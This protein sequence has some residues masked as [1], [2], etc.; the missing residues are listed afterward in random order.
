MQLTLFPEKVAGTGL[1]FPVSAVK[2]LLHGFLAAELLRQSHFGSR[3]TKHPGKAPVAFVGIYDTD[4][5][6]VHRKMTREKGRQGTFAASTPSTKQN[7]AH[8]A[9][10]PLR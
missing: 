3:D 7:G 9:E 6:A 10:S 5:P 1:P 4:R 2:P 8:G